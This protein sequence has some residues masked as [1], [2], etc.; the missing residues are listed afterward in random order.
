MNIPERMRSLP[1]HNGHPIPWLIT[2]DDRGTPQFSFNDEIKRRLAIVERLC[3]QCGQPLEYW[4]VIVGDAEV[5][6]IRRSPEPAMHEA[7]GRY[8]FSACPYLGKPDYHLRQRAARGEKSILVPWAELS[9]DRDGTPMGMFVTRGYKVTHQGPN[10]IL[11]FDPPKR[12][13][14]QPNEP[15]GDESH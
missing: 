15:S 13:V 3:G 5:L 14:W 1:Q 10:L 11:K 4:I 2:L 7:C 9:V 12:I 6:R 8:A